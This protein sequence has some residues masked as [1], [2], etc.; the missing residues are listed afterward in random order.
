[1]NARGYGGFVRT[2]RGTTLVVAMLFLVVLSMFAVASINSSTTNT[3]VTRNMIA[4]Q[5]AIAAAQWLIDWRISNLLFATDPDSIAQAYESVDLDRDGVPDH[6]PKI[7]PAPVCTR[8]RPVKANTLDPAVENDRGC[9]TSGVVPNSGL[10]TPDLAASTGNSL[11]SSTEWNV[12]AIL[13]DEAVNLSTEDQANSNEDGVKIA[14][15]QGIAVRVLATDAMDY[16]L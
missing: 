14:V 6:F 7:D 11:C 12:R 4:R 13:D 5:E 8:M 9:M 1:M 2:Q 10:D 15:N 3:L 16:C